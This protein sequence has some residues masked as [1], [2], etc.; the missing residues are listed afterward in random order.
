MR[1]GP[2]ECSPGKQTRHVGGSE[3]GLE[4]TEA[5]PGIGDT[6]GLSPITPVLDPF[7]F[8][9]RATLA[10]WLAAA[11]FSESAQAWGPVGHQTVAIAA[12]AQLTPAA[13][14]RLEELMSLEPGT[15]FAD[16]ATWADEHRSPETA[17]WHYVNFPFGD[18]NYRPARDCPDGQCIVAVLDEQLRI[19]TSQAPSSERLLALKWVVH[20]VADLHQPLHAGMAE[21]RG[22]NR[23]Q[24]QFLSRWSNLH[25]LWDSG[26][27]HH[28]GEDAPTLA[29]R[30]A[31]Q[32]WPSAPGSLSVRAAAEESCRIARKP[33]F[34]PAGAVG[35]DYIDAYSPIVEQR[36]WLASVRLAALLNR[37]LR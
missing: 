27:I 37:A 36:L 28:M 10:L 4:C 21:D 1:R 2:W 13:L 11:V 32:F 20:L 16:I 6:S 35:Q 30:L 12:R 24:L 5:P 25:S 34:Y 18:C 3:S 14:A 29:A 26:L 19:L 17:P 8:L 31:R 7:A 15:T 33:W 22:G 9:Y 23:Y